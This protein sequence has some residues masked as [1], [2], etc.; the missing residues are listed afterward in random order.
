[1]SRL[2]L[3]STREKRHAAKQHAEGHTAAELAASLQ[4]PVAW[5]T[6]A[7]RNPPPPKDDSRPTKPTAPKEPRR[8]APNLTPEDKAEIVRLRNE[9]LTYH[10]I[11]LRLG[12]S[13]ATAKAVMDAHRKQLPPVAAVLG[14]PVRAEK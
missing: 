2:L 7:L 3:L 9:G 13:Y 6:D 4:V 10:D 8:R 5:V 11:G 12:I 1:M 14:Y